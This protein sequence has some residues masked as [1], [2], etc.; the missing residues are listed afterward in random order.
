MDRIAISKLYQFRT[1]TRKMSL[2]LQRLALQRKIVGCDVI[3]VW[4]FLAGAWW[5]KSNSD[6]WLPTGNRDQHAGMRSPKQLT[7]AH[8]KLL[9][10][11]QLIPSAYNVV[12]EGDLAIEIQDS[13]QVLPCVGPYTGIIKCVSCL[14]GPEYMGFVYKA[15]KDV[16][17]YL[18]RMKSSTKFIIEWCVSEGRQMFQWQC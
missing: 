8:T 18:T 10:Q 1:R 12:G 16:R 7:N 13:V 15:Y 11:L 3:K 2:H 5:Y 4:Y 17:V 6:G 9:A 14:Q